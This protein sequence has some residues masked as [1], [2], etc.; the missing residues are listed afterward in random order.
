MNMPRMQSEK[1]SLMVICP[2]RSERPDDRREGCDRRQDDYTVLRNFDR[3]SG[4]DR[5]QRAAEDN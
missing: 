3:R 4:A 1:V 5:R 2:N